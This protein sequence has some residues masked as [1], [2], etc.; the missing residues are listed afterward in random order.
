MHLSLKSIFVLCSLRASETCIWE[1]EENTMFELMDALDKV[2]LKPGQIL[3]CRNGETVLIKEV[4]YNSM[5]IMYKGFMY[6]KKISESL[7]NTLF[8]EP[9]DEHT[10]Y[11]DIFG[12][13]KEG[14]DQNGYNQEG[15]NRD[16]YDGDG[17]SRTGYDKE[18]YDR[19]GFNRYGYDR[20]QIDRNGYDLDGYNREGF[21]R[22]GYDKYGYNS[23]GYDSTGYNREGFDQY[24]YDSAGYDSEGFDKDGY[25]KKG[26][27]KDGFN[28]DGYNSDGNNGEGEHWINVAHKLKN[29]ERELVN[30]HLCNNTGIV[31]KCKDCKEQFTFSFGE[32]AWYKEKGLSVPKRCVKCRQKKKQEREI[33]DGLR[34]TMNRNEN[35][36]VTGRQ[37]AYRYSWS[38]EE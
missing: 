14:Y 8:E 10:H 36:R 29:G 23:D 5:Y 30:G 6:I 16:G 1:D 24:G 38:Y 34:E 12:Y 9:Y 35:K 25:D 15:F 27:D 31:L 21:N 13:D 3:Y 37:M 17:F 11:Y 18:G 33:Y 4:V 22:F 20:D 28:K 2:H 19:D 32:L 26:Y 7:N